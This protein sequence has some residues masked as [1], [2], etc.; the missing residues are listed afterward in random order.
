[1]RAV[2]VLLYGL[3]LNP[4]PI[5]GPDVDAGQMVWIP[6][7]LADLPWSL[8]FDGFAFPSNG[9]ALAFYAAGM[10]LPWILYGFCIS[11]SIAW[12]YWHM[13]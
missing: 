10:G 2:A 12:I 8:S 11:K 13:K 7:I 5:G 3:W 4:V 6:F 1:M 9:L